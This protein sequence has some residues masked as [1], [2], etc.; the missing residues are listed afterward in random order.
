[1][2]R[3][4]RRPLFPADFVFHS[5]PHTMLTRLGESGVEAFTIP[6]IAGHS[7][8]VVARR[9][10]HPKPEAVERAYERL[11]LSG[12]FAEIE[13]KRLPPLQYPLHSRGRLP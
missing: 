3:I 13:P 8:I 12:D 10:I 2:K 1:M 7:G 5:L 11:Q 9:C 6:R 4:F